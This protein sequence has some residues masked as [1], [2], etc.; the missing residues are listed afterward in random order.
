MF[1]KK[2][3]KK[4][5]KIK[6]KIIN[7]FQHLNFKYKNQNSLK[8]M[9]FIPRFSFS[10][11]SREILKHSTP[12][13][14]SALVLKNLNEFL[15]GRCA[16]MGFVP[17]TRISYDQKNE[18]I[19]LFGDYNLNIDTGVW[20]VLQEN[21]SFEEIYLTKEEILLLV[22]QILK[23]LNLENEKEILKNMK[24]KVFSGE[25]LKITD[26]VNYIGEI[27]KV[28]FEEKQ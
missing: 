20:R 23:G 27:K 7:T 18:E 13:S 26:I 21:T 8:K 22:F 14:I 12:N 11:I 1:S 4:I 5:A 17:N 24:A 10:I 19:K 2:L 15:K 9:I 6:N 28:K 25:F 3:K 16:G